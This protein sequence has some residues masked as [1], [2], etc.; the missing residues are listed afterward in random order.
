MH[1]SPLQ[2]PVTW[3][4]SC[5]INYLLFKVVLKSW[6]LVGIKRLYIINKVYILERHTDQKLMALISPGTKHELCLEREILIY[7]GLINRTFLRSSPF[8]N[9]D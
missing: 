9:L 2:N 1:P 5:R 7:P 3:H 6:G 4:H 8:S